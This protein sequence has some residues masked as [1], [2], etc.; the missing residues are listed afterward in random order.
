MLLFQTGVTSGNGGNGGK[1]KMTPKFKSHTK[2]KIT[3]Q[4]TKQE[5][6]NDKP[7]R[8]NDGGRREKWH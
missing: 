5:R 1:S 4:K 2:N 6:K 8:E 3:N 7:E